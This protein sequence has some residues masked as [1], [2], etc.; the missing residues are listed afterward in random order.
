VK[1]CVCGELGVWLL[2][3]DK[4]WWCKHHVNHALQE[5]AGRDGMIRVR[6]VDHLPECA[7]TKAGMSCS[8]GS[9]KE[10]EG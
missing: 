10:G 2:D 6:G 9:Q 7:L 4:M 3:E 8:C 5:H 1:A